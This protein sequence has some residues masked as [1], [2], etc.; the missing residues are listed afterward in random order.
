MR[1]LAVLAC[2]FALLVLAIPARAEDPPAITVTVPDSYQGKDARWWAKRAVQA[3]RDANARGRTI[4]RL[5]QRWAP[6]VDYAYRLA[7]AVYHVSYWQLR[8]VGGCE[9]THNPFATNGRY[10]GV[11]Q[12]GWTPFGIFSPFD[13]VANVLSAASVVQREG[14]RQW[15]CRP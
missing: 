3:R 11:M 9:S 15:S 13:P 10:R 12:L 4:R 2:I 5:K 1:T 14:W 7:A 6:T 8:T